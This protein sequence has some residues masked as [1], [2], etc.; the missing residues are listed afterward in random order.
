MSDKH[1]SRTKRVPFDVYGCHV[2][3]VICNDIKLCFSDVR[4]HYECHECFHSVSNMLDY[5]YVR[6]ISGD[7]NEAWA[8][9]IGYLTGIALDFQ[10]ECRAEYQKKPKAKK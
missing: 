9:A 7:C 2:D 6:F 8:Y 3:V 1:W 5:R 4:K 10:A